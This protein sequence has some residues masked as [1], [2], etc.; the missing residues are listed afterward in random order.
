MS[1][2]TVSANVTRLQRTSSPAFWLDNRYCSPSPEEASSSALHSGF[3]QCL[4]KRTRTSVPP[5]DSNLNGVVCLTVQMMR[6]GFRK[7]KGS[8]YNPAVLYKT[9][10]SLFYFNTF[11]LYSVLP[12]RTDGE[13]GRFE[14]YLRHGVS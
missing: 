12:V 14:I 5:T 10:T 11:R 6:H 1:S 8:S 13:I 4:S 9:S 3:P 7:Y 2:H